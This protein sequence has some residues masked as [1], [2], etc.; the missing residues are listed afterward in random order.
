M[1]NGQMCCG[2]TKTDLVVRV[3]KDAYEEAL[4][5]PH[6]RPMDFTGRPLAGMVYVDRAG[7]RT[8]TALAKWVARGIALVTV[9]VRASR[10]RGPRVNR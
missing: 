6:A 8:A 2:L 5:L 9:D 7:Y 1:V 10:R 3:G 4:A